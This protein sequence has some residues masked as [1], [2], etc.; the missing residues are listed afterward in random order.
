MKAK[1][2]QE[3]NRAHFEVFFESKLPDLM[4]F[5]PGATKQTLRIVLQ[6]TFTEGV[7]SAV[8]NYNK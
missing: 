2:F 1:Q 4:I 6:H 5:F 8:T 7:L 3:N